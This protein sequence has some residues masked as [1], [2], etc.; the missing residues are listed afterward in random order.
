M[1]ESGSLSST[2]FDLS[3]IDTADRGEEVEIGTQFCFVCQFVPV[4]G[5]RHCRVCN[6]CVKGFDHHCRWLNTCIGV[7]NY[8]AFVSLLISSI[9]YLFIQL[10]S[11]LYLLI[12]SC[13]RSSENDEDGG[14]H[15]GLLAEKVLTGGQIAVCLVCI[16]GIG[17]LMFLHFVLIRRGMTTYTFISLQRELLQL[18][19]LQ[20]A[21]HPTNTSKILIL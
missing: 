3:W 5:S 19:D 13:R 18:W 4:E 2:G 6:K 14:E 20:D 8:R 21:L 1:S 7:N 16:Y 11:A 17:M 10:S 12:Q 9:L 15:W